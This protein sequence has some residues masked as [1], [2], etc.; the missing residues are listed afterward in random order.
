MVD[1]HPNNKWLPD[2]IRA[3]QDAGGSASLYQVYSWIGRN[4]QGL[5]GEWKAAI[6]A[7][8]Y[9]H[10]SH[11][12]GYKQ[13]NPDVFCNKGRGVWALRY[14]SEVVLGK[15]DNDLFIQAI[16]SFSKEEL[17][18]FSGKGDAFEHHVKDRAA[19]LKLK[20]KIS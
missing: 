10:S 13:G 15:T 1:A 9:L 11:A 7:T 20:Y 12:K 2:V 3:I 4:R 8:I 14:S 16:A 17:E 18:S 6:R 5:P 19:Q